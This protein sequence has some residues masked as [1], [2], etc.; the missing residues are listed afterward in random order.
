MRE[1]GEEEGICEG[2]GGR[3]LEIGEHR[4][5]WG[6]QGWKA[7]RGCKRGRKSRVKRWKITRERWQGNWDTDEERERRAWGTGKGGGEGNGPETTRQKTSNAG[8]KTQCV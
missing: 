6:K 4:E 2:N 5:V 8:Q 1:E 3:C 7:G